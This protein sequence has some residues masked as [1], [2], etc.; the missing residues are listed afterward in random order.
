MAD[1]ACFGWDMA[2][3]LVLGNF[4]GFQVVV[5]CLVGF[6]C[7]LVLLSFVGLV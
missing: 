4:G 5:A 6:G 2:I 3:W 1:L 7:L